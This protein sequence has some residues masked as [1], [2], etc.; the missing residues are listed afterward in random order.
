MSNE[1]RIATIPIICASPL[2]ASQVRLYAHS[3][4][5]AFGHYSGC[6]VW[7]E[8][9]TVRVEYHHAA[10]PLNGLELAARLQG[11]RDGLQTPKEPQ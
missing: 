9:D 10:Q 5:T 3:V 11:Y 2:I 8:E 7:L 4:L 1:I 6:Q